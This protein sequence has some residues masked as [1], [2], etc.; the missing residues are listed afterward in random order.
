MEQNFRVVVCDGK[1]LMRLDPA[2]FGVPIR[3]G[4]PSVIG[5]E[6][7]LSNAVY[8][9]LSQKPCR[10]CWM[11]SLADEPYQP[12]VDLY[13][14]TLPEEEFLEYYQAAWGR[15]GVV[16]VFLPSQF[17]SD[18]LQLAVQLK[19]K[20]A[21]LINHS[22]MACLDMGNYIGFNRT[23][24]SCLDPLPLLTACGNGRGNREY[25]P[26]APGAEQIGTWAF[27]LLSYTNKKPG[28][29]YQETRPCF[30]EKQTTVLSSLAGKTVVVTGTVPNYTRSEVE[31]MIQQAGGKMGASV[32]RS[33]DYLVV[34]DN[35]GATKLNKA[36][37]LGIPKITASDFMTM[38]N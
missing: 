20:E 5:K 17:R 11:G 21:Y 37:S 10:V 35:P 32:T 27:D 23:G 33:T 4:I 15:V 22:K 30:K 18:M 9:L 28:G 16:Q 14:D 25:P 1:M 26:S 24:D 8:I 3:L 36:A 19:T 13:A 12:G 6:N 38:L 2:D 29:E 7:R 31:F 34:A